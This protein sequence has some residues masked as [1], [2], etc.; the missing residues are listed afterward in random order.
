MNSISVKIQFLLLILLTVNTIQSDDCNKENKNSKKKVKKEKISQ[1]K[2]HQEDDHHSKKKSHRAKKE[3]DHKNKEVYSVR[4]DIRIL[5]EHMKIK[6]MTHHQLS[7][8][9]ARIHAFMKDLKKDALPMSQ[10]ETKILNNS[11]EK[12]NKSFEALPKKDKDKNLMKKVKSL[13]S[14]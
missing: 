1:G 4:R 13:K 7:S 8:F 10:T 9:V 2:S 12:A 5:E 11:I 3:S 6:N 14:C